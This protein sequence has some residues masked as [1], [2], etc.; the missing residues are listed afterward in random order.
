MEYEHAEAIL[1]PL[2]QQAEESNPSWWDDFAVFAAW[3]W[4]ELDF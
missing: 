4:P 1:Y 3:T 2:Q